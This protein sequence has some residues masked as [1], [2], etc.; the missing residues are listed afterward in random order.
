MGV[1][2]LIGFVGLVVLGHAALSTV[3]YRGVLK[4]RDEE[5]NW[6]PFQV[7]IEVCISLILCFWAALKVPGQFLP[8]LPDLDGDRLTHLSE[9]LDFMTFNHRGKVF[10]L[11]MDG[12]L[13]FR[14]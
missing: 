6:P 2:F 11:N 4:V 10:P 12:K 9:N 8:I 14:N 7:L 1:D 5:F 13:N 3:Q